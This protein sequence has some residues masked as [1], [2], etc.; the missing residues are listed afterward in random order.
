M[1]ERLRH[2]ANSGETQMIRSPLHLSLLSTVSQLP[3]TRAAITK[4]QGYKELVAVTDIPK[5]AYD[6]M[7]DGVQAQITSRQKQ[8][9][10]DIQVRMDFV[11]ELQVLKDT[12]VEHRRLSA[13]GTAKP[14]DEQRQQPTVG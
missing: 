12:I 2:R 6:G 10:R 7:I 3:I 11:T 13:N 1:A 14:G 5:T 4:L 9:V 8:D